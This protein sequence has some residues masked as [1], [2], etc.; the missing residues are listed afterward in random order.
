MY[1]FGFGKKI[2]CR[3]K[4]NILKVCGR[5]RCKYTGKNDEIS[6]VQ[7]YSISLVLPLPDVVWYIYI[8]LVRRKDRISF[9]L[10]MEML[11]RDIYPKSAQA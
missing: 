3:L 1:G 5:P 9:C 10:R 4:R 11:K 7:Y 6:I 8:D 2:Q